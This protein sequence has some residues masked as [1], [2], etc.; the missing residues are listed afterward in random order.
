MLQKSSWR[1]KTKDSAKKIS[2]E[3]LEISAF[4][5]DPK[6]IEKIHWI[7]LLGM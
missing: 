1:S 6:I 5:N 3:S 2:T 7:S 4:C